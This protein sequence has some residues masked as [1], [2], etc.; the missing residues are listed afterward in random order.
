MWADAPPEIDVARLMVETGFNL[1]V[2]ALGD[3]PCRD[4]RFD[5]SCQFVMTGMSDVQMAS[6]PEEEN[7]APLLL[8]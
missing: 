1:R 2:Q 7:L 4:P 3:A 8:A 5:T 6:W